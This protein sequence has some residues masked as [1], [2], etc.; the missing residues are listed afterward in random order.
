MIL[1]IQ[2]IDA[3]VPL[4]VNLILW[5][6]PM[7]TLTAMLDKEP[8]ILHVFQTIFADVKS[9]GLSVRRRK[10]GV[11]PRLHFKV[12]HAYL[13]D[14]FDLGDFMMFCLQFG[15]VRVEIA[16]ANSVDDRPQSIF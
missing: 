13:G 16:P 1:P 7:G 3:Q 5:R 9:V 15:K 8:R 10:W 4:S 11:V 12:S 6:S 14:V 2:V